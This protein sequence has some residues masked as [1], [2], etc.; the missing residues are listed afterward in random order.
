MAAQNVLTGS[1]IA[2]FKGIELHR[3]LISL[4]DSRGPR[5]VTH[6]PRLS[7]G[8]YRVQIEITKQNEHAT[9]DRTVKIEQNPVSID[10]QQAAP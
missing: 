6:E 4:T 9:V 1:S 7:D 8:E 2:S 3:Y 5:I 10:V